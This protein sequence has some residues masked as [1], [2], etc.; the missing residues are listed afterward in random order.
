[1]SKGFTHIVADDVLV[2][3]RD[4]GRT[5]NKS[6]YPVRW[7]LPLTVYVSLKVPMLDTIRQAYKKRGEGNK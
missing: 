7:A 5:W 2:T 1:M 3:F 6:T 4:V